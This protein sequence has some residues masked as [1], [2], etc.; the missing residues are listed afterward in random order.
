MNP[1][2]LHSAYRYDVAHVS[3]WRHTCFIMTSH[4]FQHDSKRFSQWHHTWHSVY[5]YDVKRVS[6]WRHTCFIMMSHVFQHDVT[7]VS[8]WHHNMTPN[9]FHNDITHGSLSLWRQT[10]HIIINHYL[11]YFVTDPH[12]SNC[13][14][15]NKKSISN[16]LTFF[17]ILFI[18]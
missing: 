11:E 1:A 18:K 8:S 15:W 6:S 3:S 5:C 12:P 13:F 14:L 2:S 4:M 9:V 17:I 10:Y 16:L 7:H